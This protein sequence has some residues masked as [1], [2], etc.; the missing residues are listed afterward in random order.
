MPDETGLAEAAA[1]PRRA[2]WRGLIA[3]LAV[4]GPGIITANVDN[5]AGGI[6]TYSLAGS[7]FGTKLLWTL[8]P[9]TLALVVVQEMSARMGVVT[10]KGLADLIREKFGVKVTFWISVALI[11]ANLGNVIAEFAGIAAS[12]EIFQVPRWLSV[13]LAALAVW[14]L[15]LKGTAR[16]VERV[17]L[18]ACFFYVAY[19]L[20]GFL[21]RPQWG[22]VL[23]ETVTPHVEWSGAYMAMVVGVVGTT[24]APWMQFYLQSAVVE[25][26]I[27][28]EDYALSRLDV[29]VGCIFTDVVAFFIVVACAVTL[30]QAGVKVETA[31]QAALALAPLAGQYASWLFA[32]GL[33]NASFFAASILPLSTAYYVCEAFGWESGIDRKYEEARQFYWLYSALVVLGA[34]VVLFPGLPLITIMLVSQIVNGVLLPFIL[35]FMLILVNDERLMGKWRNGRFFNAVAWATAV[36]MI[37]LTAYLVV[38]GIRDLLA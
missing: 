9:I 10:G 6:T 16:F 28:V 12:L 34:A 20:S 13:P 8:I 5:D 32:F 19:P 11:L 36:V 31:D 38:A 3:F 33:F 30:H 4:V 21:A 29:I 35:V 26:R 24:I 7:Q 37:A 1:Q 18:V 25:K 15:I 2:R 22:A 27:K 17:F 23:L 14:Y